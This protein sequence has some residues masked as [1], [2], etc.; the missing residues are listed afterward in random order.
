MQYVLVAQLLILIGVANGAPLLVTTMLG[1]RFAQPLDGGATFPDG[2]PGFGPRKTIRG[3]LVALL[4]TSLAAPAVGLDWEVGALVAAGAVVGDLFS[5]FIKRRL[6]LAPGSMALG[7]D[8]IP[9][10]LFPLLA[11]RLL[12][13]IGW[14]GIIGGTAIF[15]VGALVVSRI[16]FRL[17][18]RDTPY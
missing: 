14:L 17:K 3:V 12:V 18:L 16:L 6:G 15:L 2:R 9:E 11:S 5:S 13:P 8:H 1:T 7:L 10:S 4:A